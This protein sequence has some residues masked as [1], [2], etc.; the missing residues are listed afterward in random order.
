MRWGIGVC[1]YCATRISRLSERWFSGFYV[2]VYAA[3]KCIFKTLLPGSSDKPMLSFTT[4]AN[5]SKRKAFLMMKSCSGHGWH[6]EIVESAMEQDFEWFSLD[7]NF[8]IRQNK[9]RFMSSNKIFIESLVWRLNYSSVLSDLW[10]AVFSTWNQFFNLSWR[11]VSLF[12][13]RNWALPKIH[14]NRQSICVNSRREKVENK[15]ESASWSLKFD[16]DD[17]DL[18]K[19]RQDEEEEQEPKHHPSEVVTM[20]RN[21]VWAGQLIS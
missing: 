21:M 12:A 14:S 3:A 10:D 8:L 11:F 13:I 20:D 19:L 9:S 1:K 18:S 17:D 4:K 5:K 2:L 16:D 6:N 7:N 15:Q